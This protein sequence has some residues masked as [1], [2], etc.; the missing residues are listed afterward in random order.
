F[1]MP[2]VWVSKAFEDEVKRAGL[3]AVDTVSI[4]LTHLSE[5]IR[6]NLSQ[7]LS[8]KDLRAL[9]DGLD[10]EYRQLIDDICPSQITYSGLQ[11]VL[12]L[13]IAERVSIRNLPMIL[14]A[15]AE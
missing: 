1:G 3:S 11:A 14:E 9:L 5:V 2:A 4:V 7:L 13:L 6:N 15:V 8:Y 10:P 12:K